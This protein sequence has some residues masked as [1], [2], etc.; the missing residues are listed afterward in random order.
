MLLET[1]D[2]AGC[3]H[4]ALGHHADDVVETWLISLFYTGRAEAMAPLR[5]YFDAAVTVVRPLFE[6]QKRELL[7]LGRVAGMP[8]SA[9]TCSREV[10][11]RRLRVVE[12][13]RALGRDERLVRRQLFWA[14]VREFESGGTT[15]KAS[16]A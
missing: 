14:A 5:S 4:L 2:G 12:A 8:R 10:D 9:A 1:A 16:E 7:R 3:S 13:L 11:N 6:I 15:R